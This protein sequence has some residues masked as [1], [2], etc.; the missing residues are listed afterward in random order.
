MGSL[1][2][3]ASWYCLTADCSECNQLI[4]QKAYAHM[5]PDIRPL[6]RHGTLHI[7]GTSQR[8]DNDNDGIAHR[9]H[10]AV[11]VAEVKQNNRVVS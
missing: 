10:V 1:S 5:G 2:L 3:T 11:A 4:N 6:Y 8:Y 7:L 9:L